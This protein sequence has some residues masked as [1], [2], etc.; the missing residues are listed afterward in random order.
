LITA[1]E[2]ACRSGNDAL[3]AIVISN[4]N[5]G[6][7]FIRAIT[8]DRADLATVML[9]VNVAIAADLD[10]E[11]FTN[12]CAAAIARAAS[13]SV[14]AHA[15]NG[16]AVRILDNTVTRISLSRGRAPRSQRAMRGVA[17]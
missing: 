14:F 1:R 8:A 10:L 12:P 16:S 3:D 17:G 5:R 9:D 13:L 2:V 15:D 4:G 7:H 6:A 11:R